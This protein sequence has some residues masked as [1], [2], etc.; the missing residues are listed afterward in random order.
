MSV[1]NAPEASLKEVAIK[2]TEIQLFRFQGSELIKHWL[3][4][5]KR[6]DIERHTD[7]NTSNVGVLGEN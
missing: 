3:T 5:D 4:K 2:R 6:L 7:T 1:H